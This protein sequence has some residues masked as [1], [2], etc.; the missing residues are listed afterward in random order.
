MEFLTHLGIIRVWDIINTKT[1]YTQTNSL[2][3]KASEE[4]G[5]SITHLMLNEKSKSLA[6]VSVDHNIV[7]H[8][9]KSF[10]CLKQF[11][12]KENRFCMQNFS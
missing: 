7:I 12:G 2:I 5:L 6:V 3:S 10:T 1:V 11:V 8:H 9:L 4:G